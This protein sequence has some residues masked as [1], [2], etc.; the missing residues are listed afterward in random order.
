M[1]PETPYRDS[2][3]EDEL[4]T[5]PTETTSKTRDRPMAR[6]KPKPQGAKKWKNTSPLKQTERFTT[7]ADPIKYLER[8]AEMLMEARDLLD[9]KNGE[10]VAKAI[11]WINHA[12]NNTTPPEPI[13]ESLLEK[14]IADFTKSFNDVSVR[15]G[16]VEN[17]LTA[18]FNSA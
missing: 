13:E 4:N 16:R 11:K 9:E 17:L 18:D 1:R 15:L 10:T 14:T 7:S 8:A 3:S 6:M 5:S 12:M 2:L